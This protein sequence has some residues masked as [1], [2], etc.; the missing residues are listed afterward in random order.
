MWQ[1]QRGID[2]VIAARDPHCHDMSGVDAQSSST[3]S[4]SGL[5][6]PGFP[7]GYLASCSQIKILGCCI[8][9]GFGPARRLAPSRRQRR[10]VSAVQPILPAIDVIAAHSKPHDR[11]P[12]AKIC[13]SPCSWKLLLTSRSLREI[14]DGSNTGTAHLDLV[15]QDRLPPAPHSPAAAVTSWF[16]IR[17]GGRYGSGDALRNPGVACN[18]T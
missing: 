6:R 17:P 9:I 18:R 15:R 4:T 7:E 2:C 11:G 14:R 16:P 10:K 13:S 1:W 5:N 3:L 8:G 12:L